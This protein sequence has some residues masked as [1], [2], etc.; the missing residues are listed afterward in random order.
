[1]C[2]KRVHPGT[3]I[4]IGHNSLFYIQIE[5]QLVYAF[6]LPPAFSIWYMNLLTYVSLSFGIQGC[7]ESAV[8]ISVESLH[9]NGPNL[10]R[11]FWHCK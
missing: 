7:T 9:V 10:S 6:Y 11:L 1:M 3:I 2:I 4:C 5:N 8:S